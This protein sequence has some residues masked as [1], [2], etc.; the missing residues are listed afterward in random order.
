MIVRFVL[1]LILVIIGIASI[2]QG[3]YVVGSA[4]EAIAGF[5]FLVAALMPGA[6]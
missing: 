6:P 3:L 1:P 5:L 2:A 4:C